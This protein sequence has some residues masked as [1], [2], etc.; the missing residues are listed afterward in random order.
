M[1]CSVFF[2]SFFVAYLRYNVCKRTDFWKEYESTPSEWK[3]TEDAY[4]SAFDRYQDIYSSLGWRDKDDLMFNAV[5]LAEHRTALV[6]SIF[7]IEA[8]RMEQFDSLRERSR[9]AFEYSRLPRLLTILIRIE[10]RQNDMVDCGQND[11]ADGMEFDAHTLLSVLIEVAH[12]MRFIG[13]ADGLNKMTM[14]ELLARCYARQILPQPG[15]EEFE[16]QY[17][18]FQLLYDCLGA[19]DFTQRFR[20]IRDPLSRVF[21]L[22]YKSE[23]IHEVFKMVQVHRD[24][25]PGIDP[26]RQLL[27]QESD[28]PT[29]VTHQFNL[30]YLQEFG[31]LEVEWTNCVDEHLKIYR[32]RNAIRI[33]AHPTFFYNFR[34]LHRYVLLFPYIRSKPSL[35]PS[36]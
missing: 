23:P 9:A 14:E 10:T 8:Y 6:L 20:E 13:L 28:S 35:V 30:R 15:P 5:N 32:R 12:T 7:A 4:Q 36:D 16:R 11:G 27:L 24:L 29:F 19:L 18:Q 31:G 21:Y 1:V 26:S 25:T 17:R 22:K 33:F 3:V 34:D 2:F